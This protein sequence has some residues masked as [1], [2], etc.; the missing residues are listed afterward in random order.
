MSEL[1][2]ITLDDVEYLRKDS[3]ESKKAESLDG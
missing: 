2:T 3:I 1:K